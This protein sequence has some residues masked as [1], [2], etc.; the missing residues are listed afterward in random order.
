MKHLLFLS[1]ILLTSLISVAQVNYETTLDNALYSTNLEEVGQVY[2]GVNYTTNE[3]LIYKS[4][5]SLWKTINI[6]PPTNASLYE[7]AY[8]TTKLFNN[9]NQVELLAVFTEYVSTSDTG[10][11]FVYTTKVINEVGVTFLN[12]EGAGYSTVYNVS[13][14]QTKLVC[15][16]YDFSVSPYL[17]NTQI[18]GLPGRLSDTQVQPA[19][20]MSD[21]FPNPATSQ[22]NIPI[23]P[24]FRDSPL[25]L[26][27]LD[28]AGKVI[29]NESIPPFQQTFLLQTASLSSGTYFY[30][31]GDGSRKTSV[32]KLVIRK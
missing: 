12:L 6:V 1:V 20:F 29:Y 9:D 25:K 24:E 4:D 19:L 16:V 30:F 18:Y 2:F 14:T 28:V 10:G 5:Y 26:T 23:S 17:V 21:A 8:V 3:C 15:F 7:V 32:K 22:I 11:Y 13:D 27:L 31:L